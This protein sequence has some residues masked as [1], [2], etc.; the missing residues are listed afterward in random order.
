MRAVEYQVMSEVE[1]SHWWYE[2][3]RS[4][5]ESV[6]KKVGLLESLKGCSVLDAGCGTGGHLKWLQ[7][8][9]NST[10]LAGFDRSHEAICR[11]RKKVP[12]AQIWTDDLTQCSLTLHDKCYDLILCS[13]VIYSLDQATVFTALETLLKPL[14]SGGLFLLHVPALPWLYSHHDLSVGTRHRYRRREIDELLT[15]LGL[16]LIL[17]S[18]R[19]SILLPLVL[20]QRLPS[21]IR[22]QLQRC[23][24]ASGKMAS[25]A[26]ESADTPSQLRLPG[27]WLN[28]LLKTVMRGESW[29]LSRGGTFPV[30]CSILALG[31]KP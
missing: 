8:L 24:G 11:A 22:L 10:K 13:D 12:D 7:S 14:R 26:A 2:A 23:R 19:M 18:Y 17:V 30:G 27:T 5:M 16:E 6:L 20:L 1:D 3:Q 25:L 31:R 21:I 29:W 9:L 28:G 15:K 4:A